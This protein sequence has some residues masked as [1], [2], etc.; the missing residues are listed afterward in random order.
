MMRGLCALSVGLAVLTACS[1]CGTMQNLQGKESGPEYYGGTAVAVKEVGAAV[2]WQPKLP[3]GWFPGI[4]VLAKTCQAVNVAAAVVDV[5]LSVV[6]DTLTLPVVAAQR[7]SEP[8]PP[9][10]EQRPLGAAEPSEASA[11]AAVLS[12]PKP[13]RA[14]REQP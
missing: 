11:P 6:F 4:V 9:P 14:E 13:S 10:T 1:G 12:P 8:P 5:P 2:E 7:S 3:H